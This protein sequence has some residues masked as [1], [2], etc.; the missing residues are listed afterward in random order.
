MKIV[1][2]GTPDF[3][4]VS[5][6]YLS[7]AGIE[8]ACVFT[9]P[10]KPKGRKQLLSFSAV[11]EEALKRNIPVYQPTTLKDEEVIQQ[12]QK[13]APDFIVV[14]AFGKILPQAILDIPKLGCINLH[15]SLLPKY[16]G[17]APIQRAIINGEK[18]IGVTTMYMTAALD[19]GDIL[20]TYETE[21]RDSD[22]FETVH[23]LLAANGA[24]LL[25]ST[26]SRLEKG[27]QFAKKQEDILATYAEKIE[28]TDCKIDFSQKARDIHNRIRGLSPIPLAFSKVNGKM[29]KFIASEIVEET[30]CNPTTPGTIL[31]LEK[32]VQ[33]ACQEGSIR[34]T[35]LLPEGGKR[36]SAEDYIRGRK[37]A[38]GDCFE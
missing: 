29:I 16:R 24:K 7:D 18:R 25:Y 1:F 15:G 3:A 37:L 8:I 13:I 31:S 5:L 32:G 2:M 23:D 21:L 12:L 20:E 27:E 22:N 26:L 6:Q 36:M 14:V 9:Q 28:N 11:K 19:A 35:S 34:I 17:A 33:I 4:A 38:I 10:D 30:G